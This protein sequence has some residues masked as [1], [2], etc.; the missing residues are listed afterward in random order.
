MGIKIERILPGRKYV[1][2]EDYFEP[3]ARVLIPK[4]FTCDH[5]SILRI[6]WAIICPQDL[7]DEAP[8]T[9]DYLY[10]HAGTTTPFYLGEDHLSGAKVFSKSEADRIFKAIMIRENVQPWKR[11]A[12][13]FCVKYFAG[14][15]WNR[16][17]KKSL[18]RMMQIASLCI[19]MMFGA[20]STVQPT[21]HAQK[22]TDI[23]ATGV[24]E[25]EADDTP[26]MS[27]VKAKARETAEAGI[28]GIAESE[29][30]R[31]KAEAKAENA[32]KLANVG[33]YTIGG[34]IAIV[35][36]ILIAVFLF[37]FKIIRKRA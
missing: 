29:K 8:V 20:C 21:A 36:F 35:T 15:A 24:F 9:H 6:L 33:R 12:A 19:I 27:H 5:A 2:T 17:K 1:V 11:R 3:E 10:A 18:S 25:P 28:T 13:F 23:E 30:K 31:D 32:E 7:S 37:V 16:H 4:G 22:I 26:K 34:L 14:F